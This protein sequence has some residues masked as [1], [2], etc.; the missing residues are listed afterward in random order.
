MSWASDKARE[1]TD[2]VFK[3]ERRMT[4]PDAVER[5]IQETIERCAK[6]VDDAGSADPEVRD[7]AAAIR[8]LADP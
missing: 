3:T 1:I 7:I 6:E 8:G 2:D 4:V 5:A